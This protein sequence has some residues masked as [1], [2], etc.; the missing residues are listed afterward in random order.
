[1]SEAGTMPDF[2]MITSIVSKESLG[3]HTQTHA[4]AHTHTHTH[5][6]TT[7]TTHSHYTTYTH[8]R[9][10]HSNNKQLGHRGKIKNKTPDKIIRPTCLAI[11]SSVT[12]SCTHTRLI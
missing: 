3:T 2:T 5:T 8:T 11:D 12:T 6:H 4:R 10:P 9:A 1:M 7:H